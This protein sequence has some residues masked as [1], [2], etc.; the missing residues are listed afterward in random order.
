[1]TS[2]SLAGVQPVEPVA[3]S[4]VVPDL[5]LVEKQHDPC[6]GPPHTNNS[7][8]SLLCIMNLDNL[9]VL[10]IKYS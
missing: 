7:P 6:D 5:L 10:I 2:L 1:M 9:I 3:C 8:L 4:L